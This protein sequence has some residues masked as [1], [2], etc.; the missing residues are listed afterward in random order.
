MVGPRERRKPFR[1]EEELHWERYLAWVVWRGSQRKISFRILCSYR[2]PE[3]GWGRKLYTV[4]QES[5]KVLLDSHRRVSQVMHLAEEIG[6]LMA[7]G[8]RR[9]SFL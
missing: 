8:R 4:C 7:L 5:R 9:V 1:P 6:L 3:T 2:F